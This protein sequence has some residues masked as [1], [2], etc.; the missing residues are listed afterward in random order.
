MEDD[1]PEYSTW[2]LIVDGV[3][4][5]RIRDGAITKYAKPLSGAMNLVQ[6]GDWIQFICSENEHGIGASE[7]VCKVVH[8]QEYPDY[9]SFVGRNS[10][11]S[12]A[13][14]FDSLEELFESC[15]FPVRG[16]RVV[17]IEIEIFFHNRTYVNM[18]VAYVLPNLPHAR[19]HELLRMN[20]FITSD[21]IGHNNQWNRVRELAYQNK[22][23]SFYYD[24]LPMGAD[25]KPI[26]RS[27]HDGHIPDCPWQQTRLGARVIEV[28][29][30]DIFITSEHL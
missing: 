29:P 14:H 25:I 16:V 11:D 27:V 10:I 5:A 21:I 23:T 8:R 1:Y 9:M 19:L 26:V 13:P 24:H 15:D 4:F 18:R 7:V 2:D 28:D 12:I 17:E 22:I 30:S 6:V 20:Y 3:T